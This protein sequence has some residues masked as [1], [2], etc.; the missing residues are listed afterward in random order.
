VY[1]LYGAMLT[2]F[3]ADSALYISDALAGDSHLLNSP[4]ERI[5]STNDRIAILLPG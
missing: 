2:D 5:V 4:T 1:V 3:S